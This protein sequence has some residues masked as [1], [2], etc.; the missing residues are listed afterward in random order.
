MLLFVRTLIALLV[1]LLL[2]SAGC[3]AQVITSPKLDTQLS[4]VDSYF[5]LI[6][7][8]TSRLIAFTADPSSTGGDVFHVVSSTPNATVS[9]F[10]PNGT[11]ITAATAAASGF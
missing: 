11:E 2:F 10:L 1:T 4:A 9:L 3:S 8:G 7:V 5:E 6:P